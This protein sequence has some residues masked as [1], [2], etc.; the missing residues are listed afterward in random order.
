MLWVSC[1]SDT[2]DIVTLGDSEL[3]VVT[4][5]SANFGN[6]FGFT[7]TRFTNITIWPITTAMAVQSTAIRLASSRFL[8][9]CLIHEH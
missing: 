4:E 9:D 7:F 2:I 6:D 1:D 8:V 5:C 3:V